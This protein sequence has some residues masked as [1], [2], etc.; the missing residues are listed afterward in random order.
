MVAIHPLIAFID[1]NLLS[2]R[3][4]IHRVM[5]RV[6]KMHEINSNLSNV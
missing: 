6:R 5:D 2:K 1:N 4:E 3:G